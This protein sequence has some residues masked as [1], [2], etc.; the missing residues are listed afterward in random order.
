MGILDNVREVSKAIEEIHNLGL[1]QRVLNLHSDIVQ[2]VEENIALRSENKELK[3]TIETK[4]K[5]EHRVENYYLIQ[6]DGSSDGPFCTIC[7]DV[8]GKLVHMKVRGRNGP[9]IIYTC[10]Y[11][12]N[13]HL[14]G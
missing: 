8:D 1:Y 14:K 11:C 3:K 5:L 4:G 10:D 9:K 12:S 6:E 13:R 7:Y 2:L